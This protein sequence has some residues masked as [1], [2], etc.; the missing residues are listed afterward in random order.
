MYKIRVE[1]WKF[2]LSAL[3]LRAERCNSSGEHQRR[4]P[5]PK[6]SIPDISCVGTTKQKTPEHF[7]SLNEVLENLEQIIK[8]DGLIFI[9]VPNCA[10]EYWLNHV[11]DEPHIYF[12]SKKSLLKIFDNDKF[13]VIKLEACGESWDN[14]IKDYL[15]KN[16]PIKNLKEI[17]Y[18]D[19]GIWLR[20]LL[21]KNEK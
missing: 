2:Q 6:R 19:Q 16:V 15:K 20:M 11:N 9:E 18:D 8:K 14:Y 7:L 10:K 17:K 1:P 3:P 4:I 21:K 12:F 5:Q 13:E